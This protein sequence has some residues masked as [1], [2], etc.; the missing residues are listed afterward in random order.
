[1]RKNESRSSQRKL[2]ERVQFNQLVVAL[3]SRTDNELMA[4]VHGRSSKRKGSA[5]AIS[6]RRV[7]AAKRALVLKTRIRQAARVK[8]Q[9]PEGVDATAM[10]TGKDCP[11]EE[12]SID[13]TLCDQLNLL[14]SMDITE[15]YDIVGGYHQCRWLPSVI[16]KIK[17]ERMKELVQHARLKQSKKRRPPRQDSIDDDS[18]RP[19][20]V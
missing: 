2:N 18:L 6:L 19:R 11:Q 5:V 7:E 3:A 8:K 9:L 4:I 17:F 12:I 16:R 14:R 20:W 13:K 15:L 10:L 1:M